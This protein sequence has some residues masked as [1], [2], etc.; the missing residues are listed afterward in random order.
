MYQWLTHVHAHHPVK[1]PGNKLT[2]IWQ[3]PS[4]WG[5]AQDPIRIC[6][7]GIWSMPST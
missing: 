3:L 2:E 4:I 7:S 6:V 1:H 5:I